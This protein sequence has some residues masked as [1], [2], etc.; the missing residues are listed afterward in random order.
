MNT[1]DIL[2]QTQ[3]YVR[4]AL[5]K[6]SSGHDWWHIYRVWKNALHIAKE[7]KA[8]LFIVQMAA[9]L[10]DIGDPK[11]HQ[12][13]TTVAPRL[14]TS[15]LDQIGLEKEK[16]KEILYIIENMSFASSLEKKEIK[17]TKEF[18][19]VQDADRLDALGAIGIARCFAY[20]GHKGR[21]MHDPER[22][23]RKTS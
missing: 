14:I 19:I 11:L 22:K 3:E 17:K 20:T 23:P 15:W 13:D 4:K 12:G 16:Q 10:H 2:K 6:D 1:Q 7:E 5:E 8:D 18:C 21:L 9:L